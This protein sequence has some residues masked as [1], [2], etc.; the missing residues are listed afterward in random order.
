MSELREMAES[1]VDAQLSKDKKALHDMGFPLDWLQ[2][3]SAKRAHN[4][5]SIMKDRQ[6]QKEELAA[7]IL[8]Q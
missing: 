8:A 6:R 2:R 5:L 4:V 3:I 1:V 7:Q